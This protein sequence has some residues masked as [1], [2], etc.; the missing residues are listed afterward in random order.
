MVIARFASCLVAA[1]LVMVAHATFAQ[2]AGCDVVV[3]TGFRLREAQALTAGG[4]DFPAQTRVHVIAYGTV[5]QNGI[6]PVYAEVGTAR[7]W[8]YINAVLYRGCPPGSIAARPGDVVQAPASPPAP[9]TAPPSRGP[10]VSFGSPCASAQNCA[11]CTPLSGCGWCGATNTCVLVNATCTGPSNGTCGDGWACQLTDCPGSNECRPCTADR[12]CVS[13]RCIRRSCDGLRACAPLGR[14]AVCGIV[15]GVSCPAVSAYHA[16][17]ND[18]QC[19]SRMR[20]L[21]V[22]PGET[23][24]VCRP[25]CQSHDDCLQLEG[26]IEVCPS[27]EGACSLRCDR[28]GSCGAGM[29]CHRDATGA[30]RYCF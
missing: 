21:P 16:C 14:R 28:E 10:V 1:A 18:A 20:C 24:R 3:P 11:T 22:R 15:A 13:H 26:A 9:P 29:T 19:G 6:R 5:R 17:T 23:S 8:L 4:V 25:L 27:E 12:D 30:F 7:G 2:S